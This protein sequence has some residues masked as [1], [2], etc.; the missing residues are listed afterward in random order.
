MYDCKSLWIKASVKW[1]ILYDVGDASLW[2]HSSLGVLRSVSL[3]TFPTDFIVSYFESDLKSFPLR[4]DTINVC[5]P[6]GLERASV[7]LRHHIIVIGD[8]N[9]T[10]KSCVLCGGW[11]RGLKCLSFVIDSS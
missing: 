9:S 7:A 5:C 6:C 10:Q 8:R 11:A 1:H 3:I 2:Y 4:D